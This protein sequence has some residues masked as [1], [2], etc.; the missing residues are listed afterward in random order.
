MHIFRASLV[1]TVALLSSPLSAQQV[2]IENAP[3]SASAEK[4]VIPETA[5][6]VYIDPVTGARSATPTDEQREALAA[7]PLTL[8]YEANVVLIQ[9]RMPSGA[10]SVTRPGG[11]MSV[12]TAQA[13]PGGK[14]DIA[15]D[16]PTHHHV[17]RALG[18][19][20]TAPSREER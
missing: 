20:A 11:F 6:R 8:Q 9:E 7:D 4:G 1:L 3:Q 16:D 5:M 10:I 19:S 17:A 15:C 12:M 2:I 18:A 14:V 13:A